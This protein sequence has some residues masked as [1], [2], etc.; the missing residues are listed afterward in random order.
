MLIPY[1]I[2]LSRKRDSLPRLLIADN[3]TLE[4]TEKTSFMA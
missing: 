4:F 2:I 1:I 3:L